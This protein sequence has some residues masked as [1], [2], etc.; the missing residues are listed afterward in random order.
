MAY[1]KE[2]PPER[3][4]PLAAIPGVARVVAD[5]PGPMTYHGTNTWLIETPGG[6]LVLD[7]GPDDAAHLDAVDRAT[8]GEAVGI[9]LSHGHGDHCAG[10]A[11]L[12]ARLGVPVWGHADFASRVASIDRTL[13]EG[14]AIGGLAVLWTPGHARDH[15]C[16]ARDDGVV[17]TGDQVMAWSSSV[18]PHP[19]GSMVDFLRSLERLRDRGDRLYLPGHGPALPD[20]A[21]F[22]H[23]LIG[24]RRRREE[25]ILQALAEGP[26]TADDLTA[27]LY[28]RRGPDLYVAARNN[29][30]AHLAKLAAEGAATLG[31][32]GRWHAA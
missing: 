12:A 5:N 3:G 26:A 31:D 24:Y 19:S 10:A 14:D 22:V 28:A 1:L 17:F 9:V 15:I 32:D 6:I 23:Q 20:P 29:V 18:V 8:A 2:P 30:E 13:A 11:A 7:P 21:P 16:L 25:K 27:G 4:V